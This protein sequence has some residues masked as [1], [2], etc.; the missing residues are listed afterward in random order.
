MTCARHSSSVA[1]SD[2]A[3]DDATAVRSNSSKNV[4]GNRMARMCSWPSLVAQPARNIIQRKFGL[5]QLMRQAEIAAKGLVG[6]GVLGNRWFVGLVDVDRICVVL[7][8]DVLAR[9]GPVLELFQIRLILHRFFS[10]AWECVLSGWRIHLIPIRIL[11][12]HQPIERVVP[13]EDD[14]R[15]QAIGQRLPAQ[16]RFSF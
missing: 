12:S 15:H 8:H 6:D 7:R 5:I 2:A 11:E 9:A 3:N 4:L 16:F 13:F 14:T 1:Q 10:W